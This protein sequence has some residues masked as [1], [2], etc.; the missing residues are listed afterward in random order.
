[1]LVNGIDMVQVALR[2]PVQVTELG[3][4]PFE[5]ADLVHGAQGRGNPLLPGQ[6]GEKG[7]PHLGLTGRFRR[8]RGQRLTNHLLGFTAT[9]DVVALG[10]MEKGHEIERLPG[11]HLGLGHMQGPVN[12][13]NALT[14]VPTPRAA[15]EVEEARR[16]DTALKHEPGKIVN[17]RDVLVV[18]SHELGR[19][20]KAARR[21][22]LIL[23]FK[24]QRILFCPLQQMEPVPHPPQE[25]LGRFDCG[26]GRFRDHAL[27]EEFAPVGELEFHFGQPPGGMQIAQPATALFQVWFEQIERIALALVADATL[28]GLCLKKL[29]GSFLHQVTLNRGLKLSRQGL[30]TAQIAAIEQGGFNFEVPTG[31]TEAFPN[32]ANRM[33][34]RPAGVH[35]TVIQGLPHR[36]GIGSDFPVVEKE[37]INV[38]MRIQLAAAIAAQGKQA[39]A[40]AEAGIAPRVETGRRG[41]DVAHKLIDQR[42]MKLDH[43][44]SALPLGLL[45]S[46]QFVDLGAIAAGNLT[47]VPS[48]IKFHVRV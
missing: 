2:A 44:A 1:M 39:T 23:M 40:L 32:I 12:N 19:V 29:L 27:D 22:E 3:Q 8:E 14:D 25:I 31:M 28:F 46:K 42:G 6:D 11:E 41:K 5:Q 34:D 36:L 15:Q 17:G 13:T 45:L 35:Q 33:A 21:S 48:G 24:A 26:Q 7:I 47:E 43:G 18:G 37:Q 4:Q 38:G 10:V 9:R 30:F 20:R 16:C